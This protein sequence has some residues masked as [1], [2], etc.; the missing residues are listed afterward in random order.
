MRI[1]R[2][3]GEVDDYIRF[4]DQARKGL[5]FATDGVVI[6]VNSFA[7]R[8]S[9]GFTSKAPK[10][11]VAYKFKAEQAL[12]RIESI[13][14]QVGRTGPSPRSPTSTRCCWRARPSSGPRCTMPS[15]SHR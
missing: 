12:T 3:A 5:P 11:A 14:F 4:W 13:D 7:V 2:G 15:R 8:R 6:K 9:L 10:W 1:C